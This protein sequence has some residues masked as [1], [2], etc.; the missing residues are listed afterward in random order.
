[1]QIE[2]NGETREIDEATTVGQLLEQLELVQK[3]VAV[4]RNGAIVS[5]SR[6]ATEILQDG[7][8]IEIV[9]AI[10]GG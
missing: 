8:Q 10:G 3:R 1:M 5:R 9:H 6:H 7:D 2:I 4:E